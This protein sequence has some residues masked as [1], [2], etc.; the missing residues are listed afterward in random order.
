LQ[1]KFYTEDLEKVKERVKKY[2]S[3]GRIIKPDASR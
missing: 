3:Y 2:I 1:T